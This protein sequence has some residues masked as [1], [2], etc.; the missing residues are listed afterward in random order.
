MT[1]LVQCLTV[2]EPDRDFAFE[3]PRTWESLAPTDAESVRHCAACGEDVYGCRSRA[4][5]KAHAEQGHCIARLYRIHRRLGRL[6]AD[7]APARRPQQRCVRCNRLH[8]Q[9]DMVCPHC[10]YGR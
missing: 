5:E 1:R 7:A 8:P 9:R 10:G 3:C 2:R 4:E 6:T